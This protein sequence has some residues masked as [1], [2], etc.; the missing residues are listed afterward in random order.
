MVVMLSMATLPRLSFAEFAVVSVLRNLPM[1]SDDEIA[2]DYYI[3]AGSNNGLKTG[4]FIEAQRK[5]PVHDTLHS[6]VIGDTAVTIARLKLIHVD[7][8]VS[9]ARLVQFYER[10]SSP[11]GGFDDIMVG[12]LIR[13]AEKQ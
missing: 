3:N 7:K 4:A 8:N 9:I 1:K 6:K 2:K 5:M 10:K 13:V 12:D 11:L